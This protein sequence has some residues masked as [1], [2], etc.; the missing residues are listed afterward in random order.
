MGARSRTTSTRRLPSS[1]INFPWKVNLRAQTPSHTRRGLGRPLP[2]R[3][4]WTRRVPHPVLIGHS[5]SLTPYR[6]APR[7]ARRTRRT[8]SLEPLQRRTRAHAGAS[9]RARGEGRGVST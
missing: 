5:P 6:R 4:K 3:T 7:A 9:P 2:P 1:D 8:R